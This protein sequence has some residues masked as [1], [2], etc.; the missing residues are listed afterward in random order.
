MVILDV[1]SVRGHFIKESVFD[2]AESYL[3]LLSTSCTN[4]ILDEDREYDLFYPYFLHLYFVYKTPCMEN[5]FPRIF[6]V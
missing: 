1:A 6:V 2:Y 4:W 3:W 5:L